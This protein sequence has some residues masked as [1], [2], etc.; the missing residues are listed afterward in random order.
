MS[1]FT[2]RLDFLRAVILGAQDDPP[3]PTT[4]AGVV[5]RRGQRGGPLIS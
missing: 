2:R 3:P 1:D 5:I 4:Q